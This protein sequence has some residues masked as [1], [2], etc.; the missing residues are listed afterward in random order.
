MVWRSEQREQQ[1]ERDLGRTDV[2]RGTAAA[3][4]GAFL[5]TLLAVPVLQ[6]ATQPP[7]PK[8]LLAGLP[9]ECRLERFERRLEDDSTAGRWLLPRL[10]LLLTRWLGVGNEKVDPG[11]DGWLYHRP[12]VDYVIGPGFLG[13]DV[14]AARRLGA[15]ACE[16]PP[17]PDPVRAIVAFREELARRGIHLV[18]L[19]TPVKAVAAPEHLASAARPP[20][21]NPSYADF[22]SA[23]EASGV[24]VFGPTPLLLAPGSFLATDTHWRPEAM[25]RVA[26]ALAARL[27]EGGWLSGDGSEQLERVA[28]RVRNYGDLTRMLNLPEGQTLFPPETATIRQ[29]RRAGR[30]WRATRGAEVLLLGDSFSNVY[31]DRAA[32]GSERSGERLDWG[33]AAG[34]GE[35]LSFALARPVDRIVRNAGG[36]YTAR[37]DLAR[38]VARDAAEGRDRLAG[39]RV[40]VWQFAMRELAVGDWKEVALA[41]PPA[42]ASA[43]PAAAPAAAE[44]T[45]RAA[46]E[47]RAEPPRPGSVPYRDALIALHLRH[48]EVLGGAAVPGEILVYAFGMKDDVWTDLARLA[49][50]SQ[51]VLRVRP[52]D[53]EAVQGSVASLNRAELDDLD[54]L[55]LPAYFGEPSPEGGSRP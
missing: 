10:Q 53:D 22:R 13:P 49:P 5:A 21:Q 32:F 9:D 11:R 42:R 4:V 50:G 34:L 24:D 15:K 12:G 1:A 6:L 16:S 41:P 23:L 29:V 31:S 30:P 51:L 47:A 28:L 17:Q 33:E 27:R 18:L 43:P 2:R 55:A 39:V 54:L 45:I 52:W 44:S 37:A 40:V 8:P 19:P 20:L 46:L 48:V 38:Q 3:L 36:A 25:E 26:A 35:Q 14:L 7:D